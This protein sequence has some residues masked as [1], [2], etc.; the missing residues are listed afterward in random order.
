MGLKEY[1]YL[2]QICL[3]IL[4]HKIPSHQVVRLTIIME[5]FTNKTVGA[6]HRVYFRSACVSVSSCEYLLTIDSLE[7]AALDALVRSPPERS[8]QFSQPDLRV[9]RPVLH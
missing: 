8:V 6:V 5:G 1:K 4:P 7:D 9:R 2:C 3:V